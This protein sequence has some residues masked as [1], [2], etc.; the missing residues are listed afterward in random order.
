MFHRRH[1]HEEPWS[2]G[3]RR[4][5]RCPDLRP[6]VTANTTMQTRCS[7]LTSPLATRYAVFEVTDLRWWGSLLRRGEWQRH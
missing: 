1:F 5:S 4:K 7:Q 6:G 2:G 3:A